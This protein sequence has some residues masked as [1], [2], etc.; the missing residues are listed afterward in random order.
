MIEGELVSREC[1]L[2]RSILQRFLFR[3]WFCD[4]NSVIPYVLFGRRTFQDRREQILNLTHHI[5]DFI[6]HRTGAAGQRRKLVDAQNGRHAG[7]AHSPLNCGSR[8]YNLVCVFTTNLGT[9][10]KAFLSDTPGSRASTSVRTYWGYRIER[11]SNGNVIH[12]TYLAEPRPRSRALWY[13]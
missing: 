2:E 8:L 4:A 6:G 11:V 3:F 12:I 13:C 1:L 10:V 9:I 5:M 7:L